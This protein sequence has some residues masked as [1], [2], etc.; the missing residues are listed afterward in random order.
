M[1]KK[2]AIIG[3]SYFQAPLI[4]KAKELGIETHVFAWAANDVGETIADFFYPISIV[5]KE[6][7][8]EQCIKIGIDGICSIAS[9][10]AML[11]V[12]YVAHE[13]N[14]IS[15]SPECT[16]VTT[17][18]HL[19]RKRFEQ[20]GDPSPASYLVKSVQETKKLPISYPAIVKPIDRSGSRGIT[21][22]YSENE[23]QNAIDSA[24]KEGFD[25]RVLIEEFAE[26]EEYSVEFISWKG[27]HHFLAVTRKFTT[28]DPHFIETGHIQPS[29]LSEEMIREIKQVVGHALDSLGVEFG[30]SHSELKI[31][32]KGTI[33]LIE[34]GGR[35]G[36]DFIG[37]H[38]VRLSTG[39]DFVRGVIEV[40]LGIEPNI[41]YNDHF[42][43]AAVRFVINSEDYNAL[44]SISEKGNTHIIQSDLKELDDRV[45]SDSSNRKGYVL[46]AFDNEAAAYGFMNQ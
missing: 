5:E 34:I 27:T 21:K 32:E 23:L 2:L 9:D 13:M 6:Q 14:L 39:Y 33:R 10:L 1:R 8:L 45:V 28:G 35:M 25:K 40:A 37:S 24:Q 19:M 11:T 18:K 17:N 12:N 46:A 7:I 42:N 4:E 30:A 44:K 20:K 15:N 36:G 26:G 31:D 3:A 16:A 41:I 29:Q 22:I 38:L 43:Y